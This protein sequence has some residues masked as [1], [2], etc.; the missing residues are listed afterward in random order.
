MIQCGPLS[1]TIAM[2]AGVELDLGSTGK[3]LAADLAAT[4]AQVAVNGGG[5]LVSLGGDIATAGPAPDGGWRGLVAE[6]SSVPADGDGQVMRG[7]AGGVAASGT[8]V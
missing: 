3:A 1:R 7:Q 4:A 6:D 2:P 5:V 8:T